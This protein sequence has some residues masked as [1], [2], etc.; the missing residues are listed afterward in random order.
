MNLSLRKAA[1][2]DALDILK[3]RNDEKTMEG[4][5]TKEKITIPQHLEWF[6]KKAAD[7]DCHMFILMEDDQKAG[8]IRIDVKDGIGEISYMIAPD[9]RGKGYGKE[10]LSLLEGQLQPC[11]RGLVGFTLPGNVGSRKCFADNGYTE[12]VAGEVISY[13]KLF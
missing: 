9:K 10:I 2:E 8:H 7:P 12:F 11:I 5:F 4:S 13:I 6:K 3:W 1:M